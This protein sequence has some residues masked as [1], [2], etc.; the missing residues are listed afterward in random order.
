MKSLCGLQVIPPALALPYYARTL[1]REVVTAQHDVVTA[2][3][4]TAIVSQNLSNFETF[5]NF[6]CHEIRSPLQVV[7]GRAKTCRAPPS[8]LPFPLFATPFTS[9]LFIS[10]SLYDFAG[11]S[12]FLWDSPLT[13]DQR[14]FCTAISASAKLIVS[15]VNDVLD[16]SRLDAGKMSL[17]RVCF[18]L[19]QLVLAV[20]KQFRAHATSKGLELSVEIGPGVPRYV[21]SDARRLFQVLLNLVGNAVKFTSSGS[22]VLFVQ[23]SLLSRPPPSQ[24]QTA[25][26]TAG[27]ATSGTASMTGTG[28]G[29]GT[30]PPTP[31]RT[32]LIAFAEQK[33]E[34][35]PAHNAHASTSAAHHHIEMQKV[36]GPGGANSIAL[37]QVTLSVVDSVR[38]PSHSLSFSL[39]LTLINTHI[40][41][42]H[43]VANL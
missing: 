12:E 39:S 22:V 1:E 20:A 23:S 30:A 25:A 41:S 27:T 28:T 21:W 32:P 31:H 29:T 36:L 26:P 38:F 6:I 7:L 17:D 16:I 35:S 33:Q 42:S 14:E 43:S 18:D 19:P 34:P 2:K 4:E 24:Q 40:K 11:N 10:L 37:H 15:I 9:P 13:S 5:M 3:K 8:S